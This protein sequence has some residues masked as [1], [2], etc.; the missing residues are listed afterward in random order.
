MDTCTIKE[1]LKDFKQGIF[2]Y[3]NNVVYLLLTGQFATFHW[4]DGVRASSIYWK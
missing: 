2:C 4:I 1:M 3:I